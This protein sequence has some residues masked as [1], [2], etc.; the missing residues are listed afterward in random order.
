MV[1]KPRLFLAAYHANAQH[2]IGLHRPAGATS[3]TPD[4]NGMPR[5]N[6]SDSKATERKTPALRAD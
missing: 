5:R 3:L 1:M 2:L 6:W 4:I